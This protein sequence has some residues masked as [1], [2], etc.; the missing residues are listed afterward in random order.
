M[1]GVSTATYGWQERY[2]ADGVPFSLDRMLRDVAAAGFDAIEIDPEG[3]AAAACTR[4]GL[5]VSGAY[6]G[7]PLH[8]PWPEWE[9]ER[10]VLDLAQHLAAAGARDVVVNADPKGG[11]AARQSKSEDELRRQGDNLSR[12]AA[13][14]SAAGLRL[15]MHN[16]A[17][18]RADCEGDLRSVVEYASPEVGLC[19]DTG[20]AMVAG[21][22]PVA[23]VRQHRDRVRAVHLRNQRGTVPTEDLL[24]GDMDLGA[25]IAA[26]RGVG[27]AGW[28]TFELWHPESTRPQ[29]SMLED[30]QRS[31]REVRR[32]LSEAST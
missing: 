13:A 15:S 12:L 26:L 2:R 18:R 17:D 6:V 27:Y 10:S 30:A 32:L 4:F 11:W 8:L 5:R 19:V 31:V 20:W 1:Q 23:W 7:V 28:M 21:C 14:V 24:D 25:M 29:R 9:P 3:G 22:D 16:H